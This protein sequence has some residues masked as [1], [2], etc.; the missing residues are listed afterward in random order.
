MIIDLSEIVK[1]LFFLSFF[2]KCEETKCR[3]NEIYI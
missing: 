3:L 1:F 2:A